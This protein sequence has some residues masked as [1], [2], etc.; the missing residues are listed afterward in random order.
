MRTL[1]TA[2]AVAALGLGLGAG[3]P[4]ASGSPATLKTPKTSFI[5]VPDGADGVALSPATHT[6]WVSGFNVVSKVSAK[7]GAVSTT[8]PTPKGSAGLVAIDPSAGTVL[9]ASYGAGN[10]TLIST[11]TD[12]VTHV[13]KVATPDGIAVL[14]SLHRAYVTSVTTNRVLVI[15][16]K[17]GKVLHKI[18]V[19]HGPDAVAVN[20]KTKTVYV[21]F[22]GV[23][24]GNTFWYHGGLAV[25]S[26]KTDKITHE[27]KPPYTDDFD[28]SKNVVY[29]LNTDDIYSDVFKINGKTNKVSSTDDGNVPYAFGP[30][31]FDPKTKLLYL[32]WENQTE[33]SEG[34]DLLKP[35]SGGHPTS[36]NLSGIS[37]IAPDPGST[38]AYVSGDP[39]VQSQ[40]DD[41]TGV[42]V[43]HGN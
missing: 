14:S 6:L 8:V 19:K 22:E 43:L 29:L 37:Q 13:V 15:D 12:K 7:T 3:L 17:T 23:L 40:G 5:P 26:G 28:Q 10:V 32:G 38:L 4:G 30:F 25:I 34:I 1:V 21:S 27:I 16:T 33:D 36:L 20:T 11:K 31:A 41:A 18:T 24:N 2:A 42:E 35:S 39:Y 9:V